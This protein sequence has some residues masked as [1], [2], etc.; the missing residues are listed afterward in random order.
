VVVVE[1]TEVE[2]VVEVEEVVVVDD[3]A[4]GS[5]GSVVVDPPGSS[6]LVVGAPFGTPV[7]GTSGGTS[8][9][10]EVGS[11]PAGGDPDPLVA[12]TVMAVPAGA[13]VVVGW[14]R[15]RARRVPWS[16]RSLPVSAST[17]AWSMAASA[18][19]AATGDPVRSGAAD[20]VATPATTP[21]VARATITILMVLPGMVHPFDRSAGSLP[22]P[23]S[24]R[25]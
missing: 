10:A 19:V 3:A 15:C 24:R 13:T 16:A 11:T 8:A 12:A 9:G 4:S 25:V 20:A 2:V 1:A 5:V 17:S 14:V 22:V 6:P 21:P 7:G 23:S 18:D